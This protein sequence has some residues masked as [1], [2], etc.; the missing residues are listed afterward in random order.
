MIKH[1]C[2][3][4]DREIGGD[5]TQ[6]TGKATL[7]GREGEAFGLAVAVTVAGDIDQGEHPEL[8]ERCVATAVAQV[9]PNLRTKAP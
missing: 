1:F 2:D 5:H 7:T 4:C 6:I 8:C 3:V 9:L